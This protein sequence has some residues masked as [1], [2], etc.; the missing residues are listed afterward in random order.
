MR[1]RSGAAVEVVSQDKAI[2]L[3]GLLTHATVLY[4]YQLPS[5]RWTPGYARADG[6]NPNNHQPSDL[7]E[8]DTPAVAS[9]VQ[10]GMDQDLFSALRTLWKAEQ[11]GP[12][13]DVIHGLDGTLHKSDIHHY[14]TG[15]WGNN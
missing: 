14:L 11:W 3:D 6:T 8:Y 12:V 5:G 9:F 7:V 10:T 1:R 15:L 4:L 13:V 2:S